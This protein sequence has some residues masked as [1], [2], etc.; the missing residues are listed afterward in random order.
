MLS[1]D[2]LHALL[3][4][5]RS[6]EL[7]PVL[8]IL[9]ALFAAVTLFGTPGMSRG[10]RIGLAVGALFVCAVF[11]QAGLPAVLV[12]VAVAVLKTA[13][14]GEWSLTGMTASAALLPVI[15]PSG[16]PSYAIFAIVLR[17]VIMA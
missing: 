15:A 12:W 1:S 17:T 7:S 3:A 6:T 9:S 13:Y 14:L 11:I 4:S 16:S 8:S 5:Y 2:N 10:R